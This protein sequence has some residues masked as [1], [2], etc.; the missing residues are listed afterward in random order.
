MKKLSCVIFL[1]LLFCVISGCS[2]VAEWNCST[3]E[4]ANV[5]EPVISEM[6]VLNE[7]LKIYDINNKD[8]AEIE[9]YGKI[10]YVED[11]II[12]S[13]MSNDEIG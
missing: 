10:I 8:I 6:S 5:T 9:H 12:Y 11:F 2:R 7:T 4:D 13:K 3:Y 1:L